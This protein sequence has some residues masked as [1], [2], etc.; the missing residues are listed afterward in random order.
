MLSR[1]ELES[2]RRIAAFEMDLDMNLLID[3]IE[4]LEQSHRDTID[5][6]TGIY[7]I[8]T[9]FNFSSPVATQVFDLIIKIRRVLGDESYKKM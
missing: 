6:L 9:R 2:Y 3:H 8:L 5:K 7:Y 1:D 4:Y